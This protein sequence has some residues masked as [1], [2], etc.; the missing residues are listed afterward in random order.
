MLNK[1]PPNQL[2]TPQEFADWLG[3][4]MQTVYRMKKDGRLPIFKISPKR[5]FVDA[6]K[7]MEQGGFQ[8]G[9]K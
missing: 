4:S 3:I 2:L 9:R 8:N 7:F 5:Y 1:K 6:E